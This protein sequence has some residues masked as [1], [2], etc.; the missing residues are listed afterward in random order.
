MNEEGRGRRAGTEE[1]HATDPA[2]EHG[3]LVTPI[4]A[5]ATYEYDTTD[6]PRGAH[7]Y[8]RMSGPTRDQL[9]AAVARLE[10]ATDASAFASGMAAIDATFSLLE[11]GDCVV[12]GRSLYAETHDLLTEVYAD[13]GVDL[14]TTD[15]TDPE[16]IADAAGPETAMVYFET[17][18]NPT[19][20]IAD[21]EAA[22][23]VATDHDSLL[24]VDNTF[25]SPALQRPLELGADIAIE[26]L[27]K[28]LGG[29]SDAIAGAVA[30]RDD[31]LAERIAYYQ[32]ARG[33]IPGPLECFLVL[34]GIKTLSAR[35]E[36][37]CRNATA[38]AALL[39]GHEAVERVHYPGL[40]SH[41]NH[42]IARRQ[43]RDFGGM[44]SVELAGGVEA[45]TA[46]VSALDVFTLAESLGGV[47]S[48]AEHPATMTHQ[49]YSA[50]ELRDAGI[51][52]NLVRLSVG[53]ED[54]S[55]LLADLERALDA[56]SEV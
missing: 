4:Y 6:A 16:A 26:S 32:Y 56:A 29:H 36:R 2:D 53:I 42:D 37:H 45:A 25:A 22:A 39:D 40:E 1:V 49:D 46:F 23:A 21:V 54:E 14:T 31:D 51:P 7:R 3:A 30:T 38:V 18:A 17:P 13:Y 10:G 52:P 41:P 9:E 20:R 47:E 11:P 33:G 28:Y 50:A 8:S 24:V 55:D 48:L 43:M 15:V 34:R 5:N 19:L 27:T 12:A 35:M 44:V